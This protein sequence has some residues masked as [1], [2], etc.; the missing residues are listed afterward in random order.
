MTIELFPEQEAAL[1]RIAAWHAS[2]PFDPF[3]L[4]GPAG[5][6][7][8]T[9]AREVA[10]RLGGSVLFGAYTGKAASVLRSKGCHPASTLHSLIYRPTANDEAKEALRL[11]QQELAN[12]IDPEQIKLLE[13]QIGK[14]EQQARTIGWQINPE[15]ELA[16][17]SLLILDEVSMVNAKLAADLES[18][19]VPILV[20]GDPEQLEPVEGGGYYTDAEPDVL[21]TEIHRQALDSPVLELAT[22]VRTSTSRDFGLTAA[23]MEPASLAA[24]MEADQVLVWSNRRRWSL[25]NAMRARLGFPAGQVV[26]GDRIMCL[27]NNKDLAVFNGQQ[28]IVHGVTPAALGPTLAVEDEDGRHRTIPVFGD[29]FAGQAEQDLAKRS[30]AGVKGGR[31]LATFANAIT[32]HKAQGSEWQH[33]YVVNEAPGVAAMTAKREGAVAGVT[34]GRRWLYTAATR[35]SERVTIT[36]P[37]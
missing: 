7:K 21:L 29:G 32:V 8:T 27:T 31:M 11:A 22:R 20:L 4:F 14:L 9:L 24:A 19:G 1:G 33:V 10:A 15:S 34:A 18:F 16:Y 5:T 13:E 37:R 3:R 28:F 17:A 36:L 30:G 35:A 6:G 12:E 25:I 2:D 23:D 26:P